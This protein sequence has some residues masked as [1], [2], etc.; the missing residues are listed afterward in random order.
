VHGSIKLL[1]SLFYALLASVAIATSPLASNASAQS[2]TPDTIRWPAAA[3]WWEHGRN[4]QFWSIDVGP[5]GYAFVQFSTFDPDRRPIFLVMQ[6][7]L[8]TLTGDA[9]GEVRLQSPLYVLR[10]GQCL[11]CTYQ[12]ASVTPSEYGEAELVF[13]NREQAQFRWRDQVT[14]ITRFPLFNRAQDR[15]LQRLRGDY[16]LDWRGPEGVVRTVQV[17]LNPTTESDALQLRC[18]GFCQLFAVITDGGRALLGL[19]QKMLGL[20]IT[21]DPATDRMQVHYTPLTG[22]QYPHFR[23]GICLT[24]GYINLGNNWCGPPDPTATPVALTASA[25]RSG[26]IV[27]AASAA[28][29][30][31]ELAAGQYRLRANPYRDAAQL[32]TQQRA[33]PQRGLWWQTGRNGQFWSIDM[34]PGGYMFVNF[35]SFDASGAP[36]FLTMQGQYEAAEPSD[37]RATGRL[38][39]ALYRLQGGQCLGCSFAPATVTPSELG[40]AEIEFFSST[41]AVFRWNGLDYPIQKYPLYNRAVDAPSQRL[42]GPYWLGVRIS[43][44]SHA[45]ALVNLVV[46]PARCPALPGTTVLGV[47]KLRTVCSG[48]D[49]NARSTA[50]LFDALVNDREIHIAPYGYS[51]LQLYQRTAGACHPRG[52]LDE[53]DGKLE[54]RQGSGAQAQVYTFYPEAGWEGLK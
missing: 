44:I 45:F 18:V 3:L 24:A 32:Q 51:D 37:N 13:G 23:A 50:A 29:R 48:S 19:S 8:Q 27:I 40:K 11:G 5:G 10:G 39:S 2:A 6:G 49:C 30:D 25:E 38:H 16:V 43:E 15:L 14:T 52:R 21:A 35:G 33:A 26:G 47:Q 36:T 54:L 1:R 9:A 46:R 4:G 53:T 42:P 41:Q 22:L 17:R 20:V 7:Q 34:G 28:A 12:P 31:V